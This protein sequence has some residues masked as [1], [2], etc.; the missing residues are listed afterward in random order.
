MENNQI[1]IYENPNGNHVEVRLENDTVWLNLNQIS[2]LFGRDKSNISRHIKNI[3]SDGELTEN[4][5]VAKI[6]TVIEQGFRG[7]T[8]EELDY[9]NLDMI[10]SVGTGVTKKEAVFIPD[11]SPSLAKGNK[12]KLTITILNNRNV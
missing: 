4:A 2:T 12:C 3:F 7:T 10:I 11:Y 6:A 8:T 1:I 9:Y 5:T